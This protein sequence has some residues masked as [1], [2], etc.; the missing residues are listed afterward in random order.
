MLDKDAAN[1]FWEKLSSG[2]N[3]RKTCPVLHIREALNRMQ[4]S[5]GEKKIKPKLEWLFDITIQGWN[6]FAAGKR[7]RK[8]L[9]ITG[10]GEPFP[11]FD[12]SKPLMKKILKVLEG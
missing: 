3:L 7:C 10:P 5:F 1:E 11:L 9:V 2:A 4:I 8:P 12:G 6:L